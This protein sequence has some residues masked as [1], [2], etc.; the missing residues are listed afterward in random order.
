L[1]ASN[2]LSSTMKSSACALLP[3]LQSMRAKAS[4]FSAGGNSVETNRL[5]AA[6]GGAQRVALTNT[7]GS[8]I[9][10]A[11]HDATDNTPAPGPIETVDLR[12]E[13]EAGGVAC[14]SFTHT[15]VALLALEQ[16]L[17]GTDLGLAAR[18]RAAAAA[19]AALLDT[20]DDWLADTTD[21]L[22]GPHGTW[23]L[24]PAERISSALQGALMLREGPRRV[25]VGAETGDWNHVEVY[26]TK[27]LDYRAL[28]FPGSR[29]DNAAAQWTTQRNSTV[30]TVGA[31]DWPGARLSVRYPD[32][33]DPVVA[34]LTETLVAEL[35]AARLWVQ[36]DTG[37]TS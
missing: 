18:V 17:T 31:G 7:P 22:A 37:P 26:L 3:M 28:V 10:T 20:R 2:T 34:L 23:L 16:Q 6:C 15:L 9:T 14:R 1:T 30:V 12:A 21:A 36:A 5:F 4:T 27:T 8:P 13:V 33:H 24:A 29:W 32:D 25:A 19:T 35:V 11:G